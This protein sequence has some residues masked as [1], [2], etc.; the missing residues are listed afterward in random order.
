MGPRFV[1]ARMRT[2]TVVCP[3]ALA[4]A[5]MSWNGKMMKPGPARTPGGSPTQ[6]PER[7]EEIPS[8]DFLDRL[9]RHLAVEEKLNDAWELEASRHVPRRDDGPVPVAPERGVVVA[10][11]FD[12][13]HQVVRDR[14]RAATEEWLA[15]EARLIHDPDRSARVRDGAELFVVEVSPVRAHPGD[16]RVGHD[17]RERAIVRDDGVEEAAAIDVREIDEDTLRVERLDVRATGVGEPA[18]T[19][20]L[21]R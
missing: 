13:V 11:G 17:E 21:E 7:S 1:T 20:K 12:D 18:A 8:E 4:L 5:T 3:S 14:A 16:A 19:T 9:G 15:E 10:D 2:S 6:E